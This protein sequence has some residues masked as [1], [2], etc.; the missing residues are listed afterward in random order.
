MKKLI[1]FGASGGTGRHVVERALEAGHE[2][3]AFVRQPSAFPATHPRFRLVVGDVRLPQDVAAGCA[4]QDAVLSA[5]GPSQK[6]EPICE[7]G[8]RSILAGMHAH[9]LKRLVALSAY[10]A[11]DTHHGAYSWV[12]WTMLKT[13]MQDKER[14]E[15]LIRGSE[16]DWTLVRPPP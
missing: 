9:G 10:G 13:K 7:E 2:V 12:T 5:L 16:I 11:A 14:M 4:G 6:F 1:V 8:T 3:T 15:T